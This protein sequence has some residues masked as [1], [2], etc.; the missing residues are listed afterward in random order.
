MLTPERVLSQRLDAL[1]NALSKYTHDRAS[2]DRERILRGS[3]RSEHLNPS[4]HRARTNRLQLSQQQA[5]RHGQRQ[6]LGE[7]FGAL[8]QGGKNL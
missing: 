4:A 1:L 3:P 7:A 2:F 6:D 8:V 5:G